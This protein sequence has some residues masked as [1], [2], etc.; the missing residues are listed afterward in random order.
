MIKTVKKLMSN[1][2]YINLRI[3]TGPLASLDEKRT[4]PIFYETHHFTKRS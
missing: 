4:E 2:D 3:T 1:R